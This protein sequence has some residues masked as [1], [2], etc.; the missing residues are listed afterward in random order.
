MGNFFSNSWKK[1]HEELN[2][3]NIQLEKTIYEA[4]KKIQEADV[5]YKKTCETLREIQC[6]L[7][8]TK[9]NLERIRSIHAQDNQ[10]HIQ[11]LEDIQE[12]CES[13]LVVNRPSHSSCTGNK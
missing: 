10:V 7:E 4:N 6:E 1:K 13:V 11:I 12:L 3:Q 2:L 9:L 8:V 5:L